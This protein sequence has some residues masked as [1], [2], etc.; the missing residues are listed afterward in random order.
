MENHPFCA[1]H[2]VYA[3]RLSCEVVN[4]CA[5][6]EETH[7]E[8]ERKVYARE[9][10]GDKVNAA[11][12]LLLEVLRS[13]YLHEGRANACEERANVLPRVEMGT[14]YL[15]GGRESVFYVGETDGVLRRGTCDAHLGKEIDDVYLGKE[16]LGKETVYTVYAEMETCSDWQMEND[17][18]ADLGLHHV[19]LPRRDFPI[20]H[21][22]ADHGMN[23]PRHVLRRD[24]VSHYVR[25]DGSR[26]AV[27]PVHPDV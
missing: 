17:D 8:T 19:H 9:N 2:P 18:A 6:G 15:L 4:P 7:Y 3:S 21:H 13:V 11:C 24:R 14:A 12:H 1:S 16:T 22:G 26:L 27:N 20:P 25:V 10:G 5:L 23:L